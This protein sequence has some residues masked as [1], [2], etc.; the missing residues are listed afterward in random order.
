MQQTKNPALTAG[1]FIFTQ[2]MIYKKT[3]LHKTEAFFINNN[4]ILE[5]H[6][7]LHTAHTG[8]ALTAMAFFN[9]R[10]GNHS[11]GCNQ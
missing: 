10:F 2:T 11:F 7:A 6:A 3:P 8:S 5:A 4:L 9:R 1:F